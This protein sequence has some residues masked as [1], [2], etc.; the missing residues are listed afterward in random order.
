M[1]RA[2]IIT[3]RER[4]VRSLKVFP[5]EEIDAIC[6]EA[7]GKARQTKGGRKRIP[8]S[9][10]A[11]I[12]A[13]VQFRRAKYDL[14][15]SDACKVVDRETKTFQ[16][17]MSGGNALARYNRAVRFLDTNEDLRSLAETILAWLKANSE[18][19]GRD[20]VPSLLQRQSDGSLLATTR[21]K[22]NA[23]RKS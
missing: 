11:T 5:P 2:R 18:A 13:H 10:H 20:R 7:K 17:A 14:T 23:V 21:P 4:I 8:D 6:A 3:D 9:N 22:R 1:R 15:I 12:W 19:G 16:S